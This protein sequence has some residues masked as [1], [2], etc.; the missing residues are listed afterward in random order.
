[1]KPLN[2]P[3][4]IVYNECMVGS[5]RPCIYYFTSHVNMDLLF[6]LQTSQGSAYRRA[7]SEIRLA[8]SPAKSVCG[9]G[10]NMRKEE[11]YFDSRDNETKLHA[12]RWMPDSENVVAIVQIVHGMAEHI[13]RYGELAEFLT[14]HNF[15]VTGE[16]HLGHGKSVPEGGVKGY[17]CAQDPATVLVRDVHRLKK[18]TQEMYP[19]VPYFII[20]HSMG[21]FILR[22][23]ICRYG[24]GIDGAVLLGTGTQSAGLLFAAKALAGLQGLFLGQKHVSKMIDKAAFGGYNKQIPEAKT[25]YDW[26][27]RDEKKVA[28]YIADEDC[29]FIF[30]VNGFKTSFTMISRA[31]NPENLAKIPKELPVFVASGDKDPVG[32]YGKGVK[33]VYQSLVDMG[34]TNVKL[35]LYPEDRHELMNELDRQNIM[36]DIENWL[37]KCLAIRD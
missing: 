25:A 36:E 18:M 29:G 22:N 37:S 1:M 32:D 13:E 17:F 6:V 24:T 15:V 16:D 23:Y 14:A 31:N 12:V 11:F 28:E 26:L 9:M 3:V 20:G 33:K 30:T 4:V 7:E 21:S 2:I 27:T 19:G 34:L 5:L 10:I 35:K 8:I